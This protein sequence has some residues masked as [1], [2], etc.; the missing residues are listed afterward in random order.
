MSGFQRAYPRPLSVMVL[1]PDTRELDAI[2]EALTAQ[3]G[4]DPVEVRSYDSALRM[5]AV[6]WPTAVW[7]GSV[8]RWR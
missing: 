8:S 2:A 7:D 4:G 1:P 6:G 5:D 3:R